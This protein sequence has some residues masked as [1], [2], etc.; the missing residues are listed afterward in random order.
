MRAHQSVG[1][2]R[3]VD[4]LWRI[5]TMGE[6]VMGEERERVLG[7]KRKKRLGVEEERES[8]KYGRKKRLVVEERE[9]LKRKKRVISKRD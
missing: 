9:S 6:S 1:E 2:P 7:L 8:L 3:I 4:W 5:C